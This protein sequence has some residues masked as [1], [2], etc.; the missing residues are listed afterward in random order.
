M[1]NRNRS[2]LLRKCERKFPN[3][4]DDRIYEQRKGAV[5]KFT[6]KIAADP[7]IRTQDGPMTLRPT[8]RH[9]G[10][11]REHRQLVIVIPKK[12]R[13]VPQQDQTKRNDE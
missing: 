1:R 7:R 3:Q 9:V 5:L 4:H 6:C 2:G 10:Q 11:D 12:L 8:A 13:I